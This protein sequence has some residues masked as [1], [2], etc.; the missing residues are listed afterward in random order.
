[1]AESLPPKA[2]VLVIDDEAPICRVVTRILE[3]RGFAASSVSEQ[4]S[5]LDTLRGGHFDVILLDR[6]MITTDSMDLVHQI[7]EQSPAAKLLFFTGEI[8]DPASEALVDG[9]IQKPI[10]GRQLAE[11]L[12][13]LL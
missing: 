7:R 2:H 4:G 6:S 11:T 5:I 12:Q 3:T 10:N 1:M 13:R 9:V 8:V